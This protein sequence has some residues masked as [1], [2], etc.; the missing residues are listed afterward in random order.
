MFYCYY[1]KSCYMFTVIWNV[2]LSK[3]DTIWASSWENLFLPYANNKGTD[4][5][6]QPRSLLSSFVN[7]SLGSVITVVAIY[8][9]SRL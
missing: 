8:E 9:I 2:V 5:P 3:M 6:A 4:Q 7:R 1:K